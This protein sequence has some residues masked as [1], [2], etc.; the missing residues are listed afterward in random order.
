METRAEQTGSKYTGRWMHRTRLV[1]RVWPMYRETHL[2]IRQLTEI[3]VTGMMI[4]DAGHMEV[5]H[6]IHST[7]AYRFEMSDDD[8]DVLSA[9]AVSPARMDAGMVVKTPGSL[10]QHV[11]MDCWLEVPVTIYPDVPPRTKAGRY[12]SGMS[13]P[14]ART[15]RGETPEEAAEAAGISFRK[16]LTIES[17]DDSD[18]RLIVREIVEN[19][20]L[21]V[22]GRGVTLRRARELM[23]RA[24]Y[25]VVPGRKPEEEGGALRGYQICDRFVRWVRRL[26]KETRAA[27]SRERLQVMHEVL[28]ENGRNI[29]RAFLVENTVNRFAERVGMSRQRVMSRFLE[30]GI[31]ECMVRS[32]DQV[33][34]IGFRDTPALMNARV[35]EAVNTLE[36]FYRTLEAMGVEGGLDG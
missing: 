26:S 9:I 17:D 10:D 1:F 34:P 31:L 27:N 16:I 24:V 13:T 32:A 2:A 8:L 19:D 12:P 28:R 5:W 7:K 6:Q 23:A 4:N 22:L 36:F 14:Y 21:V 35:T 33:T 11:R 15:I 30:D 25:W 29:R 3:P 18:E 20:A